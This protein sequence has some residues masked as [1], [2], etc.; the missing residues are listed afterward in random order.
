MK[1]TVFALAIVVLFCS[2][3]GGSS[4]ADQNQNH[5]PRVP[6]VPSGPASG[7]A[8]AILEFSTSDTDPDG[9]SLEYRYDWDD[10]STSNWAGSTQGHAW[11]QLGIHNVRV[12]ARDEH[13]STSAW[14]SSFP[15]TITFGAPRNLS[16]NTG[17][18]EDHQIILNGSTVYSVWAGTIT[19]NYDIY[20]RRSTDEGITWDPPINLSNNLSTSRYPRLA[21]SGTYVYVTWGDYSTTFV[22]ENILFCRSTDGGAMGGRM[23]VVVFLTEY[24]VV[25][26]I[27][28]HL[29]LTFVAEKPP[30]AHVFEQ[31]VL[32]AAE[33]SGEYE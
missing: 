23:R 5:S 9:D 13:G 14:S 30:P 22:E 11:T 2:C 6:T 28:R 17:P 3:Q 19:G 15:T 33:E 7:I 25:D 1:A 10:G 12:Q 4:P 26:R 29:A 27:I 31:I 18:C 24:A 8:A 32:M 21:S 16:S 20:F